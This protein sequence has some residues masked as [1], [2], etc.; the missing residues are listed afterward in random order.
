VLAKQHIN[1]YYKYLQIT[2]LRGVLGAHN[3]LRSHAAG[4]RKGKVEE[5]GIRD[6]KRGGLLHLLYGMDALDY[7]RG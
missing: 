3:A 5:E 1:A 7:K 2:I 6:D 4:I